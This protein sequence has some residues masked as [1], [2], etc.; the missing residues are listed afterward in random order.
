[1]FA[2]VGTRR[3]GA[4]PLDLYRAKTAEGIQAWRDEFNMHV[5]LIHEEA[6]AEVGSVYTIT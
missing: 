6:A 3:E 4:W 1:M 2:R 5:E